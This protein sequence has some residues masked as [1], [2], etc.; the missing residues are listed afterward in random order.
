MPFFRFSFLKRFYPTVSRSAA[1]QPPPS[2]GHVITPFSPPT[3]PPRK[4][5]SQLEQELEAEAKA[6][7][8]QTTSIRSDSTTSWRTPVN[9]LIGLTLLVGIPVGALWVINLPYPAIRRP[10]ARNAPFLLLPSYIGIDHHYREA[11]SRVEQAIQLIDQATSFADIELGEEK[12]RQ[13]QNSLDQIPTGFLN[14]Y[15][16]YRYWWYYRQF[17][18]MRFNNARAKIGELQSKVFQEK[19]AHAALVQAEQAIISARQQYQEA[20]TLVDRQTAVSTWQGAIATLIQISSQTF[21]G[22]TAQQKLAMY[23]AEFQEAVGLAAGQDQTFAL[24]AAA[25]EFGWQAAKIAQN[26]PHPVSEWRQIEMLWDEAIQRLESVPTD[27][28]TGYAEAQKLLA[29]Y[30]ANLGEIKVRASAEADS[31]D[32]LQRAQMRIERLQASADRS[33]PGQTLSQLQ[34]IMND[35]NRVSTGTTVYVEAQELRV[36]TQQ[37]LDQL[38]PE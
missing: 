20:T 13:A 10:I 24:I 17:S 33:T 6:K 36:F 38:A 4:S 35:L 21:A 15:S 34:A 30:Q 37:K 14:D 25:R 16:E 29:Q 22:K 1:S 23:Q 31:V 19:N 27:N 12:V 26:P 2:A 32:A 3:T 28:P 5:L 11:I 18:L 9:R 8:S 7:R